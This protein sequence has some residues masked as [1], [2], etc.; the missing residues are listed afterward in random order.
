MLAV[1]IASMTSRA[2]SDGII[3][4]TTKRPAEEAQVPS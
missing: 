2:P 3:I 1:A 4:Y